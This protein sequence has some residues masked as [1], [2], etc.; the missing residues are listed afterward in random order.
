MRVAVIGFGVEGQAAVHYWRTRGDQVVVHE[1]N[2]PVDAPAG[3]T[4]ADDY[5]MASNRP[6]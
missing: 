1:R 4:L 5:L 3:V 6:T 2:G